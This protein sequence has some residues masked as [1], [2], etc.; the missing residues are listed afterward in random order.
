M[1]EQGWFP[2]AFFFVVMS[3]SKWCR[4][5]LCFLDSLRGWSRVLV[6]TCRIGSLKWI[7]RSLRLWGK[8]TAMQ[9]FYYI[10]C[11]VN[12][13]VYGACACVCL[14]LVLYPWNILSCFCYGKKYALGEDLGVHCFETT[15]M[16][17]D[18]RNPAP[19]DVVV[20]RFIYRVSTILVVIFRILLNVNIPYR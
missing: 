13:I 15:A 8:W 10:Q 16:V 14:K 18:G 12:A 11:T 17:V 1:L 7:W 20:D 4:D 5:D 3:S 19:V 9:W 2:S 6:S